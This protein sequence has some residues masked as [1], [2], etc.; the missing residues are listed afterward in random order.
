MKTPACFVAAVAVHALLLFGFRMGSSARPLAMSDEPAPVD[1][2]L[3]EAAP[4]PAGAPPAPP[5]PAA[6]PEPPE[7]QPTPE[8][9]PEPDMST[10]APTPDEETMP[11][12]DSTPR[13]ERPKPATHPQERKHPVP[14]SGAGAAAALAGARSPSGPR[15]PRGAVGQGAGSGPL[16]SRAS[17]L[18][19]PRPEYPAEERQLRH[20]GVVLLGVE[21]SADGRATGVSV[22]RG[23]G[24]PPLDAAAVQAV[25][26]WLFAPARA[27]GLPVPSSVQVPVRFSLSE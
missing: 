25:R 26:R 9:T 16:S 23:S 1:V 4:A 27:G 17:Y 22:I 10:P 12:P 3:V 20:Q 19:N 5:E 21:V 24:F 11:E 13:P 15:G 8:A 18:S 14:H 2:S 6:S 7:P